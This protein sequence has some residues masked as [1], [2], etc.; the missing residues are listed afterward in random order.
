MSFSVFDRIV[1]IVDVCVNVDIDVTI[2]ISQNPLVIRE[3]SI[4]E[5]WIHLYLLFL[6]IV[7]CVIT[8]VGSLIGIVPTMSTKVDSMGI[9]KSAVLRLMASKVIHRI[10]IVTS[11]RAFVEW[12]IPFTTT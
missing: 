2:G 7:I 3:M 11:Y 12:T 5:K 6:S 9:D 8:I 10:S 1:R 4:C